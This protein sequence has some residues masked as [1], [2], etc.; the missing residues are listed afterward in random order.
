MFMHLKV[1]IWYFIEDSGYGYFSA[2]LKDLVTVE[3]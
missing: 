3:L 2:L 1:Y